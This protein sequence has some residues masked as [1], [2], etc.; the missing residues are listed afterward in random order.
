MS[1]NSSGSDD[2]PNSDDTG[3]DDDS[4]SAN[5]NQAVSSWVL[6]DIL[7]VI[8]AIV[9][10]LVLLTGA[11]MHALLIAALRRAG[12]MTS[13]PHRTLFQCSVQDLLAL[14]LIVSPNFITACVGTWPFGR[15]LCVL[16]GIFVTSFFVMSLTSSVWMTL[17]RCLKLSRSD[18]WVR[19]F[20][21]NNGRV[22]VVVVSVKWLVPPASGSVA[23]TNVTSHCSVT[24]TT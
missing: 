6:V 15:G 9:L 8:A 7:P 17:E 18:W 5:L 2:A 12:R 20:E 16:E 3:D 1:N 24:T 23:Y 21:R 14:V 13:P 11:V 10:L 19:V 4:W 22:Y